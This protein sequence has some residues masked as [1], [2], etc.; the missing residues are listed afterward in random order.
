MVHPIDLV[1][2]TCCHVAVDFYRKYLSL[3]NHRSD[4]LEQRLVRCAAQ[5]SARFDLQLSSASEAHV[6]EHTRWKRSESCSDDS[7][8]QTFHEPSCWFVQ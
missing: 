4:W 3:R 5:L 8:I 1:V 6:V 7:T 2:L